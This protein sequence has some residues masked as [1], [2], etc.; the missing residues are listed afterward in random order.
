V[1]KPSL[2]QLL[3][4][5]DVLLLASS[6]SSTLHQPLRIGTS[7]MFSD[8]KRLFKKLGKSKKVKQT[9]LI[10]ADASPEVATS[11]SVAIT[12][13]TDLMPFALTSAAAESAQVNQAA[14]FT[15]SIQ[16]CP[17]FPKL[18]IHRRRLGYPGTFCPSICPEEQ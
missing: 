8:A 10:T 16:L 1:R 9:S 11:T 7:S 13:T 6:I 14:V 12:N 3:C 17:S 15:V 5:Q 18:L 2:R 4:N